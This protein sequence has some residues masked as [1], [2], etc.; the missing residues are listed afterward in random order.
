M[1][2]RSSESFVGVRKG[3]RRL[4]A[5]R[6]SCPDVVR[7]GAFGGAPPLTVAVSRTRIHFSV[8]DTR[9]IVVLTARI[10]EGRQSWS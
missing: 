4:W 2:K 1:L 9:C 6:S 8:L 5:R 3:A 7:E 10:L